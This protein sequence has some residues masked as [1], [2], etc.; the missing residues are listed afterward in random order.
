[1]QYI[2]LQSK[3][4]NELQEKNSQRP[5]QTHHNRTVERQRQNL[6]NSKKEETHYIKES[7]VSLSVDFSTE[8]P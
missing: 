2:S 1:M 7:S 8:K 5:T 6:E 4:L 3:K